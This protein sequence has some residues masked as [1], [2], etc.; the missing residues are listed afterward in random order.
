MIRKSNMT[1]S[2]AETHQVTALFAALDVEFRFA[3]QVYR[4]AL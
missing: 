1:Q 3:K 4:L 2:E